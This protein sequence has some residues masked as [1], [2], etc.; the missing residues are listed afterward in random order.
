MTTISV[1]KLS[2]RIVFVPNFRQPFDDTLVRTSLE[3]ITVASVMTF[4]VG[5]SVGQRVENNRQSIS[6][7]E[8][9]ESPL[10]THNNHLICIFSAQ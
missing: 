5:K 1:A 9:F 2:S 3:F 7:D 8:K 4:L 6:Y 10:K